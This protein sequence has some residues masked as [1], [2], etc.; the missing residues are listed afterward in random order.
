VPLKYDIYVGTYLDYFVLLR[1][2]AC[3]YLDSLKQF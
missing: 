3:L 2:S 1:V